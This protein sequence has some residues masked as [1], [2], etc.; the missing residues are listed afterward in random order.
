MT[1]NAVDV[2]A[3]VIVPTYKA[4]N[5]IIK[6]IT[7]S[8]KFVGHV[9]VVEDGCPENSADVVL[10]EFSKDSRV[11]VI[12]RDENGGVGAAMKEG[13]DWALT[14]KFKIVVKVDADGQMNV[15]EIPGM[16]RTI[17]EGKAD[18][19]KGNRFDS[20]GDLEKMPP[21][22]IFGNAALSLMA[23]T[24]TGLWS[25]N[26]STNGFFAISLPAL[27][28]VQHQKLSNRFFFESDLL[29]RAGL[30]NCVVKEISMPSIY[31]S[32]KSNLRVSRVLLTFPFLHFR[33]FLKRLIYSYFVK[34]WSLGTLN[35]LGSILMFLIAILIGVDYL[36]LNERSGNSIS[37]GQAVG[38]SMTSI[39][40]FQLLLA[41]L[42]YDVQMEERNGQKFHLFGR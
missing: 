25:I 37:V 2:D 27:K 24:S 10:Q 33:N 23:K 28:A 19:V 32:E 16:I 30:A 3:V 29:F 40:G 5:S 41:F 38:I 7:D 36:S 42:T 11:S 12:Q 8:L 1:S 20:V 31:G 17:K 22:R 6:V 14:R 21:I 15:S 9:L 26:D 39:L 13:F 18:L 35:L 4:S 34:Q